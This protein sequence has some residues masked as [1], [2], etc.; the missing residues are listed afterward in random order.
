MPIYCAL[1]KLLKNYC[2]KPAPEVCQKFVL[3][4]LR[5][6]TKYTRDPKAYDRWKTLV[7]YLYDFFTS[8]KMFWPSL[9]C[10]W[11]KVQ[12]TEKYFT[13]QRFYFSEQTDSTSPNKLIVG[14]WDVVKVRTDRSWASGLTPNAKIKRRERK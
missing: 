1:V 7:P 10:R 4:K 12:S 9:S 8:H 14:I 13:K 2:P 6:K 5:T 3:S 11:G